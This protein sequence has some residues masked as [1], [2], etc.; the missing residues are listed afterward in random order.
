MSDGE[1][2][3]QV[4]K[5]NSDD[6]NSESDEDEVIET[7]IISNSDAFECVAKGLMWLEQQTVSDSTEFDNFGT[8]R[9][10]DVSHAYGTANFRLSRCKC[11]LED[12]PNP[13]R[14]RLWCQADGSPRHSRRASSGS[15]ENPVVDAVTSRRD[16]RKRTTLAQQT[17]LTT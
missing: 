15:K 16:V 14:P 6:D 5:P 11:R 7:S 17:I 13:G 1:I 3:A 10:N 9:L 2:I 12:Q 8:E 4:R